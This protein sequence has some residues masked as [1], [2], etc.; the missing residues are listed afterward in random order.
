MVNDQKS[1]VLLDWKIAQDFH[2]QAMKTSEYPLDCGRMTCLKK[3]LVDLCGVT[4][5]EA[6]N[7]LCGR[8]VGDYIN[9]YTGRAEGKTIEN[10]GY[11]GDVQVVYKI[12]EEE[13]ELFDWN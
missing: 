11:Q 10:K 1:F 9:K 13:K 4:E 7:I 5:L 12:T 2:R 6:F 8:N 3:E